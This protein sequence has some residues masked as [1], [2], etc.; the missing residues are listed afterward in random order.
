MLDIAR[1][2]SSSL[3]RV[4]SVGLTRKA[5]DAI[6]RLQDAVEET[7]RVRTDLRKV[8]LM[9]EG[10]KKL[11]QQAEAAVAAERA[12]LE[13]DRAKLREKRRDLKRKEQ[14]HQ[15]WGRR[16]LED[17]NKA[18]KKWQD[19]RA[20]MAEERQR[21]AAE[22]EQARRQRIEAAASIEQIQRDA[23][24]QVQAALRAQHD[25]EAAR[26]EALLE[27]QTTHNKNVRIADALARLKRKAAH[28][29]THVHTQKLKIKEL[30]EQDK[31]REQQPR[32]APHSQ[33][34]S[35]S[36]PVPSPSLRGQEKRSLRDVILSDDSQS[37][38]DDESLLIGPPHKKSHLSDSQDGGYDLLLCNLA[39]GDASG[40]Q[41]RRPAQ[42]MPASLFARSNQPSTPRD[43]WTK[44]LQMAPAHHRV[45]AREPPS[46]LCDK[47]RAGS[48]ALL[49]ATGSLD[50][51]LRP[52]Q[53]NKEDVTLLMQRAVQG[54]ATGS[55]HKV[56]ASERRRRL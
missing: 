22:S 19:M 14:A 3:V 8:L 28:W 26:D 43:Q 53:P 24:R 5:Q 29:E 39:A 54:N 46:S 13:A 7:E 31:K 56:P 18:D 21:V 44:G 37:C 12:V 23:E 10:G 45:Q 30:Q 50:S 34:R 15:D 40:G 32:S 2:A 1:C 25:A 42:Q 33:P 20:Q 17:A 27:K 35:L 52:T 38:G 9:N 51:F 36:R 4:H 41:V 47:S 55:R 11:Y 6:A 16:L 48:T 49:R